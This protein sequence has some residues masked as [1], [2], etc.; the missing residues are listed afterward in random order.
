MTKVEDID[1]ASMTDAE[2]VAA[3]KEKIGEIQKN[4]KKL[5][6]KDTFIKIFKYAGDYAKLKSKDIKSAAQAKR[7]EHFNADHKA[8]LAAL[9]ATV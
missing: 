8:Y 7:C 3:A 6:V 1:I 2:F 4:D 9:Q 5:L